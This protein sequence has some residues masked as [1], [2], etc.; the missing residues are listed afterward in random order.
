MFLFGLEGSGFIISLALT[1]LISGAIM[2]Y[3]LKRFNVLESSIMDQGRVL[4]SFIVRAQQGGFGGSPPQ[5]VGPQ[6]FATD[7]ALKS[8]RD[9]T[10][11]SNKENDKI[12][13]SDNDEE[14]GNMDEESS[15]YVTTDS[16]N[17][18]RIVY[19]T[20]EASLDLHPEE[21]TTVKLDADGLIN[22]NPIPVETLPEVTDSVKIVS[23]EDLDGNFLNLEPDTASESSESD[24]DLTDTL[25]IEQVPQTDLEQPEPNKKQSL[26]KMRVDYLRSLVVESGHVADLDTA[27]KLKKDD[28]LKLLQ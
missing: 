17:D 21:I 26:S 12:E 3:C 2:F 27:K 1:L 25:G 11:Q 7:I 28:L 5:A 23:I 20:G 22:T 10:M 24:N 18:D 13:V 19:D 4:Q 16:D 9:Q 6:G 8:A 15:S 14:E